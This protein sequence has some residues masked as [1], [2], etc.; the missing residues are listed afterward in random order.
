MQCKFQE[1]AL[2]DVLMQDKQVASDLPAERKV[3]GFLSHNANNGCTKCLCSFSEGFGR[4]NFSN[5]NRDL[6][7][8]RTAIT[9]RANIRSILQSKSVSEKSK[10]ES[11]HGC[12]YSVLLELPYFDPVRMLLIDPMHNLFLGTAKRVTQTF[13]LEKQILSTSDLQT[14]HKRLSNIAVPSDLGRLPQHIESGSTFTAQQW[15]NWVLYFSLMC[16]FDL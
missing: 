13:W 15:K 5:F 6:W 2:S 10:L 16:L 9:H 12:R 8:P 3:C 14:K 7:T 11:E 1:R 4:S